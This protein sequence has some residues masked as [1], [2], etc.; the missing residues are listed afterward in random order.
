MH[1]RGPE[2]LTDHPACSR[3]AQK[4]WALATS[5]RAQNEP[6][7]TAAD[8]F[9]TPRGRPCARTGRGVRRA[10]ARAGSA[11]SPQQSE[12]INER[13][14]DA[15]GHPPGAARD[16]AAA[17]PHLARNRDDRHRH[18][19]RFGP[20]QGAPRASGTTRTR[21]RGSADGR[22]CSSAERR[23]LLDSADTI[24]S[25]ASD[26]SDFPRTS[27]L[28]ETRTFVRSFV[29]QITVK[30]GPAV[31]HY[32]IPM[33]EDSPIGSADAAEVALNQRVM[34]AVHVGRPARIR[35]WDRS[36]MSRLL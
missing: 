6:K 2:A 13:D 22:Q 34:S 10:H 27:E 25:F 35:T 8:F 32:T 33:P 1:D 23:V 4:H 29:T 5:R 17:E 36:V 18:V 16:P 12:C 21:R 26:M 14:A 19:R 15:G 30:P 28:T 7:T 20:Y 24:A 3:R 31:I 11:P 9:S